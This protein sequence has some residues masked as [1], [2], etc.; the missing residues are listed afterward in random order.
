MVELGAMKWYVLCTCLCVQCTF[1][2]WIS[3]SAYK[4]HAD[5]RNGGAE[6]RLPCWHNLV[7]PWMPSKWEMLLKLAEGLWFCVTTV[8]LGLFG[9]IECYNQDGHLFGN[10]LTLAAL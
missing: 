8:L 7:M 4:G 3:L 10:I 9:R 2:V 5:V 1:A 6:A